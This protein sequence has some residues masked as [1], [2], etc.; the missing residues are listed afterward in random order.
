MKLLDEI[1]DGASTAGVPIAVLLRRTLVLA[2]SLKA[3]AF[4]DWCSAE[5]DG[6][7]D[8]DSVPDYRRFECHSLGF[9]ISAAGTIDKQPIPLSLL[10]KEHREAVREVVMSSGVAELEALIADGD[11]KRTFSSP[12]SPDMTALYQARIIQGYALNRAW[13]DIPAPRVAGICD[14]IRN[15][16][17]RL[18][19]ELREQVGDSEQPLEKLTPAQVE[20]KM[21]T[22]I[23]GGQN[24]VGSTIGRD[25]TQ[26][27]TGAVIQGD[28]ASLHQSLVDQGIPESEIATLDHAIKQDGNILGENTQGW[29]KRASEAVG[30][31]L[32]VEAISAAVKAYLGIG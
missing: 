11:M 30:G 16:L 24:V 8:Q 9:L 21:V 7:P 12:W 14:T 28:R 26:A 25:V 19:L 15:R 17:L 6:Y 3:M 10:S 1:I 29:I 31:G 5:L 23:F 13:R 22:Y 32:A 20:T 4:K 27:S 18:L 2:S